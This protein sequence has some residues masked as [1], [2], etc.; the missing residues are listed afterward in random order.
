MAAESGDTTTQPSDK[1][2]LGSASTG[3]SFWSVDADEGTT[4]GSTQRLLHLSFL[5]LVAAQSTRT[6]R[7]V[8]KNARDDPTRTIMFAS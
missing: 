6:Q 7:F 1:W 3:A 5:G 2:L 4:P 8:R